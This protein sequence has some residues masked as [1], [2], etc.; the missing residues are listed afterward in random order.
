[1]EWKHTPFSWMRVFFYDLFFD[2]DRTLPGRLTKKIQQKNKHIKSNGIDPKFIF[3][4]L[5]QFMR[6]P[7][8]TCWTFVNAIGKKVILIRRIEFD[9]FQKDPKADCRQLYYL[10]DT[11]NKKQWESEEWSAYFKLSINS[12][13]ACSEPPTRNHCKITKQCDK[14]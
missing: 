12:G 14:W 11:Q 1:M 7:Q 6:H 8:L 4:L 10:N 5:F 13:V 2:C 3:Q 9:F